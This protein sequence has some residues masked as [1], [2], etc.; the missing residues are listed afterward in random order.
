MKGHSERRQRFENVS[1]VDLQ[2]TG[3]TY[4]HIWN[5]QLHKMFYKLEHLF[6]RG[7]HPGDVGA[8]IESVDNDVRRRLP[9]HLKHF[10]ETFREKIFRRLHCASRVIRIQIRQNLIAGIGLGAELE[11]KGGEETAEV[12][13]LIVLKIEI[14]V[15]D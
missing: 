4:V 9:R 8:L 5:A 10:D 14:K 7:R 15:S 13:L 3:G 6:T 12:L 11:N 2:A 1:N